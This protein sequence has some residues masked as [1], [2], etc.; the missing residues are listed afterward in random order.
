MSIV[1]PD[2]T[3]VRDRWGIGH[4]SAPDCAAA[5]RAQ[6]WVAAADRFWQMEWDRLRALG[7]WAGVAGAAAVDDDRLLRRIDLG[8]WSRRHWDALDP[9]TRAMTEAYAEG[10]NAW[11]DDP[12]TTRPA[13]L[14]LHPGPVERWEPWHC[15][16]VYKIRHLFMGTFHRKLWRGLVTVA[17]G[18]VV[19]RA[20][21]TDPGSPI[22]VGRPPGPDPLV[23]AAAL[24]AEAAGRLGFLTELEGGSN[25]WAVHGSRTATGRPLLAGDPHRAIEFPNVY[26]QIHL[27]C[28][29]FDAIGLGFPGVPGLPHFGHNER[30]AWC[31]THGM[32]DDTDV[33]VEPADA[34]TWDRSESIEVAGSGPVVVPCGTTARGPVIA[35]RPGEERCLSMA[36]TG[37][38][39]DTTFDCL[40]PMLS[41]VSV[42]ELEDAVDRWVLPV[43]S[44]LTADVDGDISFRLRGRVV[45]RPAANRW[46]PVP[47]DDGHGWD[48]QPVVDP[49][50]SHRW[51]NPERGYLVTANN[52]IGDGPPYVSLDFAG[53]ARHDRIAELLDG[54]EAATVDDMATIHADTVSLVAAA[55]VPI[56]TGARP[57]TDVGHRALATLAGWDRRLD[58][59]SPGATI[60]AGLR[61]RWCETVADALGVG[62]IAVGATGLPST[63][64]ASRMLFDGTITLLR[65]GSWRLVPGLDDENDLGHLLGRLADEVAAELTAD[66]GADI[67]GWR[68]DRRH[69]MVSPHPLAAARPEA[70]HLHPPVDGAGGDGDTVRCGTVHPATGDRMA[71]SSVARYAFDLADWD[72]SGWVVPHGVSGVRGSGHD[73]DQRAAWL[74]CE[75]LPMAYSPAAVA[76]VAAS[77]ETL[78]LGPGH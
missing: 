4:V 78:P 69:V 3:L 14:T 47:G 44:L 11:L 48:G 51:R 32:A 57:V 15:V 8:S 54:L 64:S 9:D 5:F 70:T 22:M 56:L 33:F 21:V 65:T 63:P 52:H 43:N 67:D 76:A 75:L 34:V 45:E 41:A 55:L 25:S 18:P 49:G 16:A 42:D 35:G 37:F 53:P 73:L 38:L 46:T 77:S 2:V 28:P 62:D 71:A 60:Y 31:I 72:R 59:D 29:D 1:R 10:V 74:A 39:P 19:A 13:E 50:R 24:L 7:R 68:W 20:M 17:A 36:W 40:L 66:L 30:V 23:D 27:R 61:R 58:G 6:G 26:H 12:A